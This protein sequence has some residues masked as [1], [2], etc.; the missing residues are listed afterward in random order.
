MWQ[1]FAL[2]MNAGLNPPSAAGS[3]LPVVWHTLFELR[4]RQ[5]TVI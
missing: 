1:G 5:V 4:R 2:S 3:A